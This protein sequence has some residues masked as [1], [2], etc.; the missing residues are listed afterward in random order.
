MAEIEHHH[1]FKVL[2][3][4]LDGISKLLQEMNEADAEA[5]VRM[6]LAAERI[7][8]TG[9]GRSGKIAE[10]FAV[11]LMQMGFVSHVP[12]ESTC[13][14]IRA[15]DLMVTISCS[16]TTS[17]TV[18]LARIARE[19][20]ATI[21]CITA[22]PG[23]DLTQ[24]SHHTILVPTTGADV[25]RLYRYVVGPHNNTL[26]EQAVLLYCDAVIYSILE[27]EGIPEERLRQLHTNLE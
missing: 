10:C 2:R 18:Q 23:S 3:T 13:P 25:K 16:G 5:L 6:I 17:T 22:V 9:K 21:V 26:F 7:F 1:V 19:A 8:V 14:R 20:G 12:G 11:R 15:G 24:T 27:S 4:R